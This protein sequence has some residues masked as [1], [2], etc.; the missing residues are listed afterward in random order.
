LP[1]ACGGLVHFWGA[2][3][4]FTTTRLKNAGIQKSVSETAPFRMGMA[5]IKVPD[6]YIYTGFKVKKAFFCQTNGGLPVSF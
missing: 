3:F 2:E 6:F 4:S 5:D 1:A